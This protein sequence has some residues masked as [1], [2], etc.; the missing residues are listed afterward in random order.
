M[1]V[2]VKATELKNG[3]T[4]ALFKQ[5]LAATSAAAASSAPAKITAVQNATTQATNLAN[6][7][8]LAP[9]A[10]FS[11]GAWLASPTVLRPGGAPVFVK[12]MNAANAELIKTR[13]IWP[14][15]QG[16]TVGTG[17]TGAGKKVLMWDGGFDG[18]PDNTH[19]EFL[20]GGVS[21]IS[22]QSAGFA[23]TH[24]TA[25][26][27][28]LA[29]AGLTA[30]ARGMAFESVVEARV[31]PSDLPFMLGTNS[32]A[33]L[34]D[35]RV[36]NHSYG[37]DH[38]WTYLVADWTGQLDVYLLWE[39]DTALSQVESNFYGL[40]TQQSRD[41]D[42]QSYE[43]PYW[44]M[45]FAAGNQR[46]EVANTSWSFID[47]GQPTLFYATFRGTSLGLTN[48]GLPGASSPVFIPITTNPLALGTAVNIPNVFPS[49]DGGIAGFDTLSGSAVSKNALVVAS[50]DGDRRLTSVA[51]N[52]A[53]GPTDDGRMKPDVVA[54]GVD[55]DTTDISGAYSTFSGTSLASPAVAGSA[56]LISFRHE[57]LW[58][59]KDPMRA[60]TLRALIC[61]T[62]DDVVYDHV[63]P[64]N[65]TPAQIAEKDALDVKAGPDYKTGWGTMDTAEAITVVNANHASNFQGIP[66]KPFIK[67]VFLP[68]GGQIDFSVRATGAAPV[69]VSVA[70]T[71]PA[72]VAQTSDVLDPSGSRLVNDVDMTVVRTLAGGTTQTFRPW[73]LDPTAPGNAAVRDAVGNSRDNIEVVE[74]TT[75]ATTNQIHR[76]IVKEKTA[77][78]LQ[79]VNPSTG[80]LEPGGQWVSI[81]LSGVNAPTINFAITTFKINFAAGQVHAELNWNAVVG[82]TYRIQ[83]STDLIN[84]TWNSGDIHALSETMTASSL[85]LPQG[86]S[87]F[88]RLA[89]VR[90]NPFDLP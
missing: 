11:N 41:W 21:R 42:S 28:S 45:V 82:Q 74:T 7:L 18:L 86:G 81:I 89:A 65:P 12:S 29:A 3:S 22:L 58:S 88:Y 50:V 39:G 85:Q 73:R 8:G 57:E 32:L 25:V 46:G 64:A 60:S 72:G 87:R 43:K 68:R 52:T 27:G 33:T 35:I 31:Q 54:R 30:S 13:H 69:K 10:F 76:I 5:I 55:V 59:A 79:S 14:A 4:P 17:L 61:H 15:A 44:Q 56:N 51:Q 66:M 78:T 70:W 2:F 84:W 9:A 40:Y 53:H 47:I 48:I 77:N 63:L 49:A 26:A 71:D 23:D 37:L 67:E 34:K 24:A 6:S 16:G 83:T 62:A 90:H 38:G 19:P 1:R 80:A 20:S 36:S 75:N